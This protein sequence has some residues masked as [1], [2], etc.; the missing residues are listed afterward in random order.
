MDLWAVHVK[1]TNPNPFVLRNSIPEK[2]IFW[3]LRKMGYFRVEDG[4]A[5]EMKD[6]KR[7]ASSSSVYQSFVV[8]AMG[9]KNHENSNS[10]SSSVFGC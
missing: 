3:N 5:F 1:N 4:R 10:P 8:K 7:K 2:P 9:K 6:L